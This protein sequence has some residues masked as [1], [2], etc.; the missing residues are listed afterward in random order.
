MLVFYRLL[1]AVFVK[2][3]EFPALVPRLRV[4]GALSWPNA[5]R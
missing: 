2:W 3:A 1:R 4:T 5:V